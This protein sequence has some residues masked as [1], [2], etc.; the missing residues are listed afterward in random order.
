VAQLPSLVRGSLWYKARLGALLGKI[1]FLDKIALLG[2][3]LL[4]H[5]AQSPSLVR[6]LLSY[7]AR[8]PYSKRGVKLQSPSLVNA[9]QS[10]SSARSLL[11]PFSAHGTNAIILI[12][13]RQCDG[14]KGGCG[15]IPGALPRVAGLVMICSP[16]AFR[17]EGLVVIR[18][19]FALFGEGHVIALLGASSPITLLG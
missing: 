4:L 11:L 5:G 14:G 7:L 8:S 10:L 6:G 15:W 1:A 17:G 2:E 19:S 9:A 3:S 16:I 18:S 12:A 13:E